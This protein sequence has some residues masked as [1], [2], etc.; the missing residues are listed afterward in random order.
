MGLLG[1]S[2]L[3]TN[4]NCVYRAVHQLVSFLPEQRECSGEC[5]RI[6]TETAALAAGKG[7][8]RIMTRFEE[9]IRLILT[10]IYPDLPQ[11]DYNKYVRMK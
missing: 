6:F 5:S 7:S 2:D 3:T 10:L 1:R 11:S 4:R 9:E 8:P